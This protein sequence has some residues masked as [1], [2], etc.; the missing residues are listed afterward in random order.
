M[1]YIA[2]LSVVVLS[3][4]SVLRGVGG[5]ASGLFSGGGGDEV[6]YAA[7]GSVCGDPR[8][9]GA[10][11][12]AVEGAGRCGIADAV[13]VTEVAGVALSTP[14]R[15][16]CQTAGALLTWVEE[17]AKPAVGNRGGGIASMRVMASY[18]CRTRNSRPGAR[19][20]EHALGHAIDI[21]G[22]TLKDGT[23]ISVL[24][25]WGGRSYGG[26]LRQMRSAACGP[27]GTVLGPGSDAYHDNHF[28]FDTARYRS[29]PYCR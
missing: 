14:A 15:I 13:R 10:A 18:A 29:G 27:F 7:E 23:V 5:L 8:I 19:L 3:G 20:S 16:D 24:N 11:I 25:H 2:I 9:R 17:G 12:G 1:K 22:V 28:H 6:S 21:G 26:V 4:C